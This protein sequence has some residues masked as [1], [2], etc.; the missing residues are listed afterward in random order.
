MVNSFKYLAHYK[1][2]LLRFI[3]CGKCGINGSKCINGIKCSCNVV[4]YFNV[5]NFF[6]VCIKLK[7]HLTHMP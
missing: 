5:A 7:Y 1:N 4:T 2:S 6:M 3:M